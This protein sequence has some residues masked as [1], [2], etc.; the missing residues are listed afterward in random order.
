MEK[1]SR[2]RPAPADAALELKRH[3]IQPVLLKPHNKA[4]VH[5]E[6]QKQQ[7]SEANIPQL[8][9]GSHNVG[10]W[11]ALIRVEPDFPFAR[12]AADDH[13]DLSPTP[14]PRVA[15]PDPEILTE[16]LSPSMSGSDG[17]GLNTSLHLGEK[18]RGAP[19]WDRCATRTQFGVK[20][21]L[22]D[23]DNRSARGTQESTA[24]HP[25]H[26]QRSAR[27]KQ[28]KL[29]LT[30]H[31]R[32]LR[33]ARVFVRLESPI[34]GRFFSVHHRRIDYVA[35]ERP[36]N[37]R[38]VE[39]SLVLDEIDAHKGEIDIGMDVNDFSA[40]LLPLERRHAN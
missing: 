11:L 16:Q 36:S 10:V 29:V 19:D 20:R 13:V 30:A 38:S 18:L 23:R 22:H 28:Q 17:R 5:N 27:F 4:P 12:R 21:R 31:Q 37:H 3:G 8:F 40:A 25:A 14:L 9:S 15:E 7:L 26:N 33:D 39:G 1:L 2:P 34:P 6:W 32:L 24:A 35:G